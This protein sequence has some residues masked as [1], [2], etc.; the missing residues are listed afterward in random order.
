[1]TR[2]AEPKSTARGKTEGTVGHR[3][4]ASQRNEPKEY[5]LDD[6]IGRLMRRSYQRHTV[7]FLAEMNSLAL[8]EPQF[9]ALVLIRGEEV[10]QNQ[11]GRM[12]ATDPA[13]IQGVV[14]RLS[15]RDLIVS[16]RDPSD[17]RRSLWRLTRKGK[18]LLRKAIPRAFKIT[19]R[20]LE[21][22]DETEAKIFIS[23]MRK[24]I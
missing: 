19:R 15:A 13:T 12:A 18:G 22:L 24:L 17:L 10:S 14:D 11:L 23:L 8:T 3:Q 5:V 7:I 4:K 16:R 6:Q 9:A 1:M 2:T 21:P 20:T